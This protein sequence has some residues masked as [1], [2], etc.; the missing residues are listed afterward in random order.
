MSVV[1]LSTRTIRRILVILLTLGL[2]VFGLAAP[3]V[4]NADTTPAPG[5]PATVSA[6]GLPTWQIN[7]VVWSQVVVGTTVYATGNFSK[8]RPPGVAVGGAGE[9]AAANIFAYNIT[10]GNP[11]TSFSHQM[12]AQGLAIAASPD[13]S[14]IFVGGD[15]TS[16]DGTP[17]GHIAAFDTAT[18]AL[19]ATFA[20]AISSQ[21]RA[22]ATTSTTVFAGGSYLKVGSTSRSRL[23]AF[24]PSSGA[25]LPWA[26]IADSN[27]W[28]LAMSPDQSRVI[29]GGSFTTLGGI[30]A[31]GMGSTDASSGAIMPW[32]AN[33]KI[34]DAGVNG[35][36]LSLRS[37]GTQIYGSGF[38][39][40]AGANFEGTF[41]AD[42]NTGAINWANDCHGD[43]YD[44][45][46]VGQVLYSVSHAHDCSAIGDYPDTN[47]RVRWQHALASTTYPTGTNTGPDDVGWDYSGIADS[48]LLQWFPDFTDGTFTGQSQAAWSLAGNAS[49]VVAGG[50][51]PKVNGVAQQG[52]VRFA[53]TSLA[54]NKR[55]PSYNTLP[56]TPIPPTTAASFTAGTARVG[57]GTAWDM[58][59]ETLT[60]A[61]LR[62]GKTWVNTQVLKSNFWT[63]PR[64]G[65]VDTGLTPGSTHVYQVR[66]SDPFGNIQW[67]PISNTV[68]ISSATESA[69]SQAVKADGATSYWRLGE[70]SGTSVL[71]HVGFNDA[72]A[73]SGVGRGVAGAIM[74]DPDQASSFDGSASGYVVT[75]ST[76]AVTPDFTVEA[77]VKTTSTSG[78]K[79]VGYGDSPT[80][81]S[82]SYDRHVY[83]DNAGHIWF[84]VYPGGNRTVNSA[85]TYNDGT[86]HHVVAS[87]DSTNGMALYI[88]G[89]RVGHDA[90]TTTAQASTG[91][92]RIGGDNLNGWP[93]QPSSN[94]L[95]GSIDDVAVYPTALTLAQVQAHFTDSG[96]TL[97][98]SPIPTDA[99][100]KAVY[101]S[102]PDLYWRLGEAAGPT[103]MDTSPN[104][105]NGD[106]S[107]GVTY[108]VSAGMA[109]TT[110]TAITLD[111]ST[112]AVNSSAPESSPS[113]YS[114]ELR[115]RTTTNQG[116]KLIGFGDQPT[117]LSGN[118][119]RHVYMLDSG[120]LRFGVWTGQANTVDSPMSYN[121]GLWHHLVATQGPD[122]MKLYVDGQVVGTNPQTGSQPFTGYW[123][124]GGDTC[125]GGSSS[126][127][128][129]GSIDEVAVYSSVLSST[130]VSAHFV[131]SGGTLANQSPVASF[132]SSAVN[133]VASF[134]GSGSK[135]PDGT[136]ASYS[137]NFGD[138]S[139]AGSGVKPSHTYAAAGTYQVT[140]T[141][142]D[143]L[144]ATGTVTQP[145]TM[146][147]P[148]PFIVDTF[149]RTLTSGWGSADT[150]GAW[151][152]STS[153]LSVAGGVGYM[154]LATAGSAPSSYAWLNATNTTNADLTVTMSSD[155]V[156]TG[157]GVYLFAVGRRVSAAGDYRLQ[158]RLR[159]D[160]LV[161]VSILRTDA[162][163]VQ[164]VIT[165]EA[166]V[167][168]Y[169]FVAGDKLN[170]RFQVTGTSP[171]TLRA[172]VWPAALTEPA[173]WLVTGTDTTAGLQVA[174]SIG[175]VSFLS[176]TGTNPPVTTSFDNLYVRPTSP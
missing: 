48:T 89:K 124:V 39:F 152:G 137:W 19:V 115:F 146:T 149:G 104:G 134:D 67:S 30:S 72:T 95:A 32:A 59:N 99:Y 23:S 144:G 56:A 28:A 66:I 49:Y 31:Y 1:A 24:D 87:L 42:P 105:A 75:N 148:T 68:T 158:T 79:I 27:V 25:L 80:S 46:P 108:G 150:G 163:G 43:T 176:G 40:G 62:D 58:D 60:Y 102:S 135:D 61:V 168:G 109:G 126:N 103:A 133:L 174:G 7:G 81:T 10:T 37:D 170:I 175:F 14:K 132:T 8:A 138:G 82:S 45:L 52:L 94:F 13:G 78:G 165:A 143:N 121:D 128:F 9:I 125:W 22:L 15:F 162:A 98:I 100:G 2:S 38:S 147:A 142:T 139:A 12:N 4:A 101:N 21:V 36:I 88:D 159:A 117:G 16:I 129:A 54:P 55:G 65:F 123:R 86:W 120:Q 6:D 44:V 106:Y 145:A 166:T 76:V 3:Q 110:N 29:V 5:V 153:S 157:N 113:V 63:L 93:N 17:R 92:W 154:R 112:G 85:G 114:E 34:Q 122:G 155:K 64:S 172:K 47:P 107:G 18:G 90:S 33:Q 96:R 83:M 161:G 26:P 156:G 136:V 111:G 35:A 53:V 160:G 57:F 151:T 140:L 127:Y 77:W 50:E 167:P 131:A 41:A 141:V 71:D 118:Y 73:Q 91:Y 116:G 169:H 51:F 20:P 164:T 74:G 119:D 69:Y 70:P 173:A 171:T 84:G 11:V 97:A 130:D